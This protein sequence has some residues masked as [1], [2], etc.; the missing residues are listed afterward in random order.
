MTLRS[1][2]YQ[3]DYRSGYNN[4]V[5]EFFRPSL[6]EAS[7]Y[8]RA[9]GY[10]SSTALES[11]GSTLGEFILND[12]KICLVTSVE[13]TEADLK[14][15]ANGTP[16]EVICAERVVQ[17]VSEEFADGVGDG[18]ARLSRLLELGRL[19]IRIAIPK[20]GSGIYHEKIGVFQDSDGEYVAFSGSSN[21]SR[22]AFENNREC[23]DVYPAWESPVRAARKRQHFEQVWSGT[24]IGVEVY[25]FPEAAKQRLLQAYRAH[26]RAPQPPSNNKWRHQD[27]ALKVFLAAERGVL[28]MATGTGKTRTAVKIAKT[29]FDQG[30]IDN[31]ILAMDGT[32]LLNQWYEELLS[33]RRQLGR[34][35]QVYRDYEAHKEL[36]DFS[37]STR[38]RIL[39]VSRRGGADRDPLSSALAALDHRAAKRTL[40][41]HDEV[42]RLG[43]AGARRRLQGLSDVVRYRLGL[44]ATPDREYDDDGNTFIEE[45]IGPVLMS[46]E[47]SDAIERGILAPFNYHALP[48]ELTR[49]DRERIRA[50]YRK[51]AARAAA[52]DPMRDEDVWIELAKVHKTSPAKLPVFDEFIA[53]HQELLERCIVFVETTEYGR[54]VLELI[55]KYRPDFHS[56]FTDEQSTTLRRFARGDLQCLVTCHR[57]SEGID[58]HSL[59]SVILFSSPRARLETIQRI[60]RCLRS[61]PSNP[62]KVA[63][64]VDFTRDSDVE[65]QSSDGERSAWLTELTEVRCKEPDA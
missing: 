59:N 7:S 9:V 53:E 3:E 14:A 46:F 49:E 4:L 45:H 50:V 12:G 2:R 62:Q 15:I 32:D 31:V 56:Y 55:H 48:Y 39:L 16:K 26:S 44:S 21:E 51:K 35:P 23:I 37:L 13:L 47:L 64:I 8:W 25:S 20:H 58:I 57:L 1:I 61:D 60:G 36:A 40:L 42:H 63:N 34:S 22:N 18:V 52:G 11:F 6:R 28:N 33:A 17:I 5:E 19:E 24:D 10:F 54:Q 30:K 38:E 43:S 27:E 65:T 29:L 41:I